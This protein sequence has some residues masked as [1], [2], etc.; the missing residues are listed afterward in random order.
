MNC[1]EDENMNDY[2][3]EGYEKGSRCNVTNPREFVLRNFHPKI[4]K[5]RRCLWEKLWKIMTMLLLFYSLQ[6]RV[7][8][9]Y[10]MNSVHRYLHFN[11]SWLISLINC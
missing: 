10:V 7:V 2:E 8:R 3:D 9:W 1:Q 4:I 11:F 6:G 5:N